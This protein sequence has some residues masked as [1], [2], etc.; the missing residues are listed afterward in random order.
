MAMQ[1]PDSQQAPCAD[2]GIRFVE[3]HEGLCHACYSQLRQLNRLKRLLQQG[4]DEPTCWHCHSVAPL[5][6]G[7]CEACRT[8]L[9]GWED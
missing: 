6:G 4:Q 8:T 1:T 7:L 2:C 3:L 5:H 9:A